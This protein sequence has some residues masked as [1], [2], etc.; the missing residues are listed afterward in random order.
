VAR[1]KG[2]RGVPGKRK[3]NKEVE[4]KK[5]KDERGKLSGDASCAGEQNGKIKRVN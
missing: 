2:R 4:K 3:K 5:N 1:A